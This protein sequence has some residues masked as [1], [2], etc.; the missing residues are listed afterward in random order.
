MRR[1]VVKGNVKTTGG[2]ETNEGLELSKSH[3]SRGQCSC[4]NIL[5]H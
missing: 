4:G 2:V 3:Q 1:D 5:L